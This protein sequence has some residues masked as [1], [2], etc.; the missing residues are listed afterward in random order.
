[1]NALKECPS[2]TSL[3]LNATENGHTAVF[4]L[5][6]RSEFPCLR[7]IELHF[8]PAVITLS[9]QPSSAMSGSESNSDEHPRQHERLKAIP[10]ALANRLQSVLI[11]STPWRARDR[12]WYG[13]IAAHFGH[14]NTPGVMHLD[15]PDRYFAPESEA[16]DDD[17]EDSLKAALREFDR[18]LSAGSAAFAKQ[19]ADL[20]SEHQISGRYHVLNIL[21]LSLTKIG[22][23]DDTALSDPQDDET[24]SQD[25]DESSGLNLDSSNDEDYV[26]EEVSD[27][28]EG[29]GSSDSDE[30]VE[31][32]GVEEEY[33]L[34]TVCREPKVPNLDP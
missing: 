32:V 17:E 14:A 2:V 10:L 31:M 7:T 23:L 11:C 16:D 15:V 21:W 28:T 34:R 6:N 13:R 22:I 8:Y 4:T 18:L 3:R 5:L 1:V 33:M 29:Y 30:E 19:L 12:E 20:H 26:Y 27:C 24:K 25:S 9:F